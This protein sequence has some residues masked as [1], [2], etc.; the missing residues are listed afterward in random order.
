[1]ETRPSFSLTSSS[2]LA[3]PYSLSEPLQYCGPVALPCTAV[4]PA[5]ATAERRSGCELECSCIAVSMAQ[6]EYLRVAGTSVCYYCTRPVLDCCPASAGESVVHAGAPSS[7]YCTVTMVFS[8]KFS[9]IRSASVDCFFKTF[10]Y[11]SVGFV[12]TVFVYACRRIAGRLFAVRA[13]R[14]ARS[15]KS[16]RRPRVSETTNSGTLRSN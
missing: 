1:M 13:P 10:S 7:G 9:A 6:L 14:G 11:S 12:Q 5:G 4:P 3:M 15:F 8:H 2:W 16:V